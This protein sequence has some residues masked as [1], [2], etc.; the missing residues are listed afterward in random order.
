[1]GGHADDNHAELTA[2]A[3]N[4]TLNIP[5]NKW[6]EYVAALPSKGVQQEYANLL[7]AFATEFDKLAATQRI[8]PVASQELNWRIEDLRNE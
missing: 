1:M 6:Q 5:R 7:E 4:V 8:G 2:S 3:L